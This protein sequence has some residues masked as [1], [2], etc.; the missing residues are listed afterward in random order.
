MVAG[1]ITTIIGIFIGL[2]IDRMREPN[3]QIVLDANDI[4]PFKHNGIDS[5]VLLLQ[6]ENLQI[7]VIPSPIADFFHIKR[8]SASCTG[9][10]SCYRPIS[11]ELLWKDMPVRFASV[12]QPI[13]DI[14]IKITT[15]YD[16]HH[17]YNAYVFDDYIARN[18]SKDNVEVDK[19]KSISVVFRQP[20]DKSCWGFNN[21][22]Y[23][24]DYR[25]PEFELPLG[26]YLVK[27]DRE[28]RIT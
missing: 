20:Q 22:S 17:I 28:L 6:V 13:G 9:Y 2:M 21:K 16:R 27:V 4:S 23:K 8:R 11:G 15:P 19:P 5:K 1:I 12:R 18:P 3:L 26:I 7:K 24:S 10:I 14:H 25:N